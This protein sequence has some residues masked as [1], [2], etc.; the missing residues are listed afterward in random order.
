MPWFGFYIYYCFI[1]WCR[2]YGVSA[3][4]WACAK[5]V[6]IADVSQ[7]RD[8]RSCVE[9]VSCDREAEYVD[10]KSVYTG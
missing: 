9:A 7:R 2:S 5:E 8:L 4:E 1:Y 3:K 10:D 6:G